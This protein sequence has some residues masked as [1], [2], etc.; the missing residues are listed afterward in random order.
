M[1]RL[2]L[3][4]GL[5]YMLFT[6]RRLFVGWFVLLTLASAQAQTLA[7][8]KTS[9]FTL[10]NGL[11]VIIRQDR[12]A[13]VVTSQLWY[14]VGSSYETPGSTGLA[15]VLEHMMFKGSSKLG[16]GESSRILRELGAEENAFTS[17]D[18]TSYYQVIARDRL[19]VA[20]EMEADRLK[21]ITLDEQE[22]LRELEVVKEERRMRTDDNPDGLAYERFKALAY[23]SSSY[24][25]PTIGWMHDLERMR[26]EDLRHWHQNW[27]APNNAILVLVGDITPE[28]ALP[29]VKR[30]FAAIKARPLPARK[31]PRELPVPGE[32]RASLTINNSQPGLLLGFN[33]PGLITAENQREV[34]AL[35]L[36]SA[37]LDSGRS[38]RLYRQLVQEQQL[39]SY[40]ASWYNPFTRG[41]SLFVLKAS[42]NL[43]KNI[44]LEQAEQ[45]IWQQLEQLKNQP[46]SSR[47]LQRIRAQLL[48]SQ[49]YANDSI[50]RI[51]RNI[52]ILESVGL[53]WQ[54]MLT[55]S[56]QLN[57]VTA[58]DIQAAARKYFNKDRS[59]TL[60]SQPAGDQQ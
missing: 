40:A 16:P 42:P 54:Q 48:A 33:V 41:D 50:S 52:G 37:L 55:D 19:E 27:Y 13:P 4:L 1:M 49:T 44:D 35:R 25:I 58:E 28:Q 10:D 21:A 34:H 32:R 43:Q 36:I 26:I 24:H 56:Q 51:G 29:L 3:A 7:D 23:P 18:F 46:V 53:G 12:R 60:H 20:L 22:F 15:H 45:A 39:L 47:E 30:H 11:K 38:A 9:E 6:L 17:D 8:A 59:V 2:L 31:T 57:A 5:F 14:R